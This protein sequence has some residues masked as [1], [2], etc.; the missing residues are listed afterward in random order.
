MN[1]MNQLAVPTSFENLFLSNGRLMVRREA[2]ERRYRESENLVLFV[3]EF[4]RLQLAADQSR[5][6]SLLEW[7]EQ[8][9]R[10]PGA[11]TRPEAHWV[12]SRA[13]ERLKWAVPGWVN[14]PC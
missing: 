10:P 3:S 5:E 9:V 4:L 13:A 1:E 8:L 6:V 14:E 7:M 11:V 12:V 2:L